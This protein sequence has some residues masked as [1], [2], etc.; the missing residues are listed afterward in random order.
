MPVLAMPKYPYYSKC[1]YARD[2]ITGRPV[3]P[4]N[5][6][7]GGSYV[8]VC[9]DR[10]SVYLRKGEKNEPH[11]A[12][13]PVR[14]E[15]GEV[16][17]GMCRGGGGES[18]EHINAKLRMLEMQGQYSF[19]CEKCP[20]CKHETVEQCIGGKMDVELR[21]DDAKWRYDLMYTRQDGTRIA[22]EIFHT[23]KSG[24]DK[25]HGT[26]E[27]LVGI[28]EFHAYDVLNMEPGA[29]LENTLVERKICSVKCQVRLHMMKKAEAERVAIEK[30]KIEREAKE[31]A[32]ATKRWLEELERYRVENAKRLEEE[33]RRDEDARL[34][35]EAQK[36]KQIEENAKHH[37]AKRE[38]AFASL[39]KVQNVCKNDK[40]C[41]VKRKR[42]NKERQDKAAEKAR[43]DAE[44]AKFVRRCKN[45]PW[46]LKAEDLEAKPVA[47]LGKKEASLTLGAD[48]IMRNSEGVPVTHWG[49]PFSL[50]CH[51]G[52]S[53]RLAC[54]KC[55]AEQRTMQPLSSDSP[56]S[57]VLH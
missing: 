26:R 24:Q 38:C 36:R 17:E 20:I 56:H 11:F 42:E 19:V 45:E 39:T 55:G 10:H 14:N 15:N 51:H 32:E 49:D 30:A 52:T 33:R 16:H 43:A 18:K 2:A 27:S 35:A 7:K 31:A 50:I 37:Y 41:S 54:S 12:H 53:R 34:L 6:E 40:E 57:V 5:A 28:A 44:H 29:K 48:G 25:I 4:R 21:S 46:F 13:F 9:P 47:P 1:C 3:A 8:C 23:H 22:L